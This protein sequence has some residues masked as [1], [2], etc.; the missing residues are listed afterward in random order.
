M[1]AARMKKNMAFA[2]QS[3]RLCSFNY[4]QIQAVAVL[5]HHFGKHSL[6]DPSWCPY[7][8]YPD[9]PKKLA[10]HKYWNKEDHFSLYIQIKKFMIIILAMNS[11]H[12]LAHV[13]YQ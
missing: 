9:I 3:Y 7:H 5:E 1:D 4:F 10:Q 12:N 6:C 8:Q 2:V 13:D 11:Y